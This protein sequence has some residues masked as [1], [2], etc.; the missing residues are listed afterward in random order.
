MSRQMVAP[1]LACVDAPRGGLVHFSPN[2]YLDAR[3][4]EWAALEAR[5]AI[6]YHAGLRWVL[7]HEAHMDVVCAIRAGLA[8]VP[9]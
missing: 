5:G 6:R 9:A 2:I 1:D 7:V 4:P 8:E 3:R